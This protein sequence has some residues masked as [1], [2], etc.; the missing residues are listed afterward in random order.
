MANNYET[1][2]ITRNDLG[3]NI[4]KILATETIISLFPRSKDRI[5]KSVVYCDDG[6]DILADS[7][8]LDDS[9]LPNHTADSNNSDR[10][11]GYDDIQIDFPFKTPEYNF[12]MG[13]RETKR[14]TDLNNNIVEAP[15]CIKKLTLFFLKTVGG[16]H[17]FRHIYTELKERVKELLDDDM[18]DDY[19][20]IMDDLDPEDVLLISLE[21]AP[22]G[23]T[24]LYNGVQ[25]TELN[26]PV[27]DLILDEGMKELGIIATEYAE[28]DNATFKVLC[29][30]RNADDQS[31][32]DLLE[33]EFNL[34]TNNLVTDIETIA[35][36]SGDDIWVYPG[37]DVTET[38]SDGIKKLQYICNQVVSRNKK[39]GKYEFLD[40]EGQFDKKTKKALD[41]FTTYFSL[42]S[43]EDFPYLAN[44]INRAQSE[45]VPVF[46]QDQAWEDYFTSQYGISSE[47][48]KGNIVDKRLLAGDNGTRN[49]LA[50]TDGL[51]SL[52]ENVVEEFQNKFVE[53]AMEYVNN[54]LSWFSPPGQ[55]TFY[56]MGAVTLQSDKLIYDKDSDTVLQDSDGNNLTISSGS[57]V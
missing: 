22:N 45:G 23:M 43:A 53:R 51:I 21:N 31:V 52:Y 30:L 49:D 44:V 12:Y 32:L 47:G 15:V 19:S 18:C 56:Q 24:L 16:K 3:Q 11:P 50:N 6:E 54:G 46:G 38:A 29:K 20:E 40:E 42:L 25:F 37:D 39:V 5:L 27:R 9:L 41:Q 28:S 17:L 35:G 2:V 1:V 57:S 10:F 36:G 55:N 4:R 33:L 13:M 14:Y 8:E 26:L 7:F 48:I 34:V